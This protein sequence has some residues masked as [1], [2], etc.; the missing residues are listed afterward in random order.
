MAVLVIFPKSLG[1]RLVPLPL[2]LLPSGIT[3]REPQL[4]STVSRASGGAVL[5]TWLSKDIIQ[6][7]P[8]RTLDGRQT[9]SF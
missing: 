1:T 9:V 4:P 7:T 8:G 5:Q 2:T 6:D 3:W